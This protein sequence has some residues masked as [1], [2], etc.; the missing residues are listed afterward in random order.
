MKF[1]FTIDALSSS[2][3]EAWRLEKECGSWRSITYAEPLQISDA[4]L[5]EP[6]ELSQWL[7]MRMQ[8]SRELGLTPYKKSN[9]FDFLMRGVFTHLVLHRL[10]A[11][12]IPDQVQMVKTIASLAIGTPWLLYLNVAGQFEALNTQTDS[13]LKSVVIA[14]RGEI[15][16]SPE[17]IGVEAAK[18]E[19]M[20]AVLYVQ[21]LGGW[22]EHLKTKNMQVFIPDAKDVKEKE[23][24]LQAIADW[25]PEGVI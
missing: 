8:K 12:P 5:T 3:K 2:G 11:A 9:P 18:N 19:E 25:Q 16:S 21:F 7:N 14:V 4:L 23:A 20:M 17:Y 22:L 6:D 10:S 24:W 13:I 1:G 15:A